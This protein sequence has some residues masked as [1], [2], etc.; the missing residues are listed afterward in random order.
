MS[1]LPA[2]E[3]GLW[4]AWIFI[5]PFL[6]T[7]LSF[8]AVNREKMGEERLPEK[9]KKFS[10]IFQVTLFGSWIYSVFLP[11]QLGTSWFYAGLAVYLA[12]MIFFAAAALVFTATPKGRVVTKG[13]YLI[14]RNP[15][16]VGGFLMYIGIAIACV[17][18]IFLLSAI[19]FITIM[20]RLVVFEE[21]FCLGKFG[22]AYREHMN[23]TPRWIGITKPRKK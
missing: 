14:S 6:L 15:M 18:W 17:S 16:Y 13:V 11:L 23:R 12:G 22:K 10:I 8:M 20:R 21:A 3:L 9:E 1:L 2:F 7:W 5:L 4:N 19:V